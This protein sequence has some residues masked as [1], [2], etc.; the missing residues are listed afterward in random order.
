MPAYIAFSTVVLT[1]VFLTPHLMNWAHT[2]HYPKCGKWSCPEY[3]VIGG[4]IIPNFRQIAH[5]SRAAGIIL[6]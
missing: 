3:H 2:V 5:K 4:S 6:A 1:G